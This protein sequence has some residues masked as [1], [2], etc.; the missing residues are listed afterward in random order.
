MKEL[1]FRQLREANIKRL[2]EF[3]NSKGE[4]AHKFPDGSDWTLSDWCTALT[5]ELGEAA[6]IIKKIRRG[7]VELVDVRAKLADEFADIQ[8]YLDILAFQANIDLGKAV[9]HKF[10]RVSARVGSSVKL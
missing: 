9:I 5:G 1:T 10:N 4:L 7:D 3:R 6:N 8:T 2:P